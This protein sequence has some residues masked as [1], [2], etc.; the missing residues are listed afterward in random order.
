M[1]IPSRI[2]DL[3]D[4]F[5]A[6]LEFYTSSQYNETQA[7]QEF[8]D[9]LFEALGWDIGNRQGA[10][11]A[12]REVVLEYSLKIGDTTKAPDYLFRVG[13]APRFFVEA[14]KPSVNLKESYAP[15]YQVRRYA[16]TARLPLSILTDFDEFVVYDTRVEPSQND[17]ATTARHL[18]LPY[19]AYADKWDTIAE[20]FHR[21]AVLGGSLDRFAQAVKAPKGS[22]TVDK[23]FLAE[24]D[25]WRELLAKN[26]YLWEKTLSTRDLNYAVQMTL[27][28]IIFLRIAEDRGIEVYGR[29]QELLK[30]GEV[31]KRLLRLFELAD[32]KYNS[33]LFHFSA[34][35]GRSEA[36]D[37]LT[38]TLHIDDEVLKTIIRG[39]YYPDSPYE[40]SVLPIEVLG[41]VYEQFLGKV[42]TI[43]ARDKVTVE[44]KP[45]VRKAG[46]VY[47]TPQYIVDYIVANTVG[48]LLEGKSPKQAEQLRILDPACGSGSFLIGAYQHLLDWH[49]RQYVAAGPQK[50]KKQI[51]QAQ[52]GEW[53]LTVPE[54]KRILLSNIFGVDLD[55]QAVE[56]TKLSLCLKMLEGENANSLA[57]QQSF[58]QDRVLPDLS[59]NIKCGNSLIGPDFYQLEAATA[60][61][62]EELLRI[63]PFDWH[64]EFPAAMR[65]GGFDAVIGNPPYVR[66][67][68]IEHVISDYIYKSYKSPIGKA[69]L[70][71]VFLEKSLLLLREEGV[72]GFICTSQWLSTDYGRN[73]RAAFSEGKVY[74]IVNFGA[75]P[76]FEGAD[77]YP[78]IFI[79]GINN[80]PG[81]YVKHIDNTSRLNLP[82]IEAVGSIFI[83]TTSLNASPWNLSS[84]DIVTSMKD[85]NIHWRP[86]KSFGK[87]YY[88]IVTGMDAA[89]VVGSE[90]IKQ[91]SLETEILYPFAY[92]G[93]EVERYKTIEP[94][95]FIIYP[96]H[97]VDNEEARLIPE[98]ELSVEYPNVYRHLL[99]YKD[100]LMLRMDSRR[101]FAG[102][103]NWYCHVRSGNFQHILSRKFLVK[104]I[105]VRVSVGLLDSGNA[106]SG[107][108]CPGIIL[109]A[110]CGFSDMY[111]WGL[112]NSR[113]MTYYL[114]RVC[115]PKLGGYT[116]FNANSISEAPIRTINFA[117][118][119]DKARHDQVVGL[120]ERMLDLHKRLPGAKTPQ[121]RALL[122]RQVD[123]TDRQIDA[124]VYELYG[125]SEAEIAIVEGAAE[126]AKP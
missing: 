40:F 96:Y 54:R 119:A 121:E 53:Q 36:P 126:R 112:I 20:L 19:T 30:G 33:G 103:D 120:V 50:H 81:V 110:E 82:S 109:E 57:F 4:R 42:I 38:P 45:E 41:N 6:D 35:R 89:F 115:P 5:Q 108:N 87:A 23:A 25:G 100:R 48:K 95:V 7:R 79:L 8:I 71:L 29:L 76:V 9:P 61:S 106:F 24:I 124:L 62:D 64:A 74:E 1:P 67:Q 70:S 11:A 14:K 55:A 37:T 111:F 27:D 78:A 10:A 2:L 107:A 116:R 73:L 99:L 97:N 43:G 75:L 118:P 77:T 44:E 92:R 69:D 31:Y 113:V 68:R 66:I 39:L 85:R 26:I 60:L 122:Q 28:R 56:V 21:D 34:E 93:N 80:A 98:V 63:N 125:L 90:V 102:N 91:E 52:N 104:G 32:N 17:K 22:L 86:L 51:Y 18:Y 15:A 101:Y 16:W 65:A 105:D 13:A 94:G 72:A 117:D 46:G 58:I 3:V 12:F 47:Y 49:V 84:L 88:S 83:P 59:A 114:R 123:A